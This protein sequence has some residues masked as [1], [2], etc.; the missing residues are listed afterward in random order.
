MPR[1][2]NRHHVTTPGRPSALRC[3][4]VWLLVTAAL[5][6]LALLCASEAMAARAAVADPTRV[7]EQGVV[8]VAAVAGAWASVHV[9]ALSSLT[10]LDLLRASRSDRATGA[11]FTRRLRVTQ[12]TGLV[13]RLTLIACGVAVSAGAALPAHA[14]EPVQQAPTSELAILDGLPYPDRASTTEEGPAAPP[15]L[16]VRHEPEKE[17]RSA[18]SAERTVQAGDSLWVIAEDLTGS[19]DPATVAREVDR[20]YHANRSE[21]GDDPDLIHPGQRLRVQPGEQRPAVPRTSTSPSDTSQP[22]TDRSQEGPR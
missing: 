10:V 19:R 21:I 8:L 13:R 6:P 14:T 11:A 7:A 15:E 2:V 1:E 22:R 5:W 17:P 4:S 18:P 9:W 16:P 3:L 20:L 12:G